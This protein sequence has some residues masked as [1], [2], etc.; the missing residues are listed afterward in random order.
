M[1][2]IGTILNQRFRLD[3]ELGR[4][5]MGAV[6]SA[7]D[8]ILQR[9]VAI[10]VLKERSG[11]EVGKKLR[12]EA[13]IAARL[14]HEN[15]VRIYDF[16]QA[17]GTYYLV[18][19]EVN[20]SSYSKRWRH[21]A[22]EDRL[23]ILSQVAEALD[24]AHH[25]GVVHRDIKPSNVLLTAANTPKLSDFGLSILVEQGDTS[26]LVRGTPL[27]MSPEQT[28][29]SQLD[30]RTDLYS[31]GVMLY[32]ST[33]G[34]P[35][36]S[37]VPMQI[38]VQHASHHPDP[39]RGR[40]PAISDDLEGLILSLL[41]KRPEDRPGSGSAVAEVLRQEMERVVQRP[42]AGATAA[43]SAGVSA[44]PT[45]VSPTEPQAPARPATA[46]ANGAGLTSAGS[47]PPATSMVS[48]S[49]RAGPFT[50]GAVTVPPAGPDGSLPASPASGS[51]SGV[52]TAPRPAVAIASVAGTGGVTA[53]IRSPL[54]RRMIE[55]VLAEPIMLSPE[56]RYLHGHYLAYLLS[57]S[58]RRGLFLR[59]PTDPR[60]AD[61]AR[62]LLGLTYAILAESTDEAIQDVAALLDQKI[63]VRPMLSPV[64][65]AKYLGGR[66]NPT[67]RKVFRQIRRA[68]A[69]ASAYAQQHMIDSKG[70]LNP[71][72]M[73]Q[74]LE[75]LHHV[76]PPRTEVDDVLVERW[77]RVAEVWRNEPDFRTAVLRYATK[78]AHRDPASTALWPE[79][80][81]PLIE[82][83]RWHRRI[84]SRTEAVWDYLCARVLRAPDAGVR[85]DRALDRAVPAPLVA[86][87]DE[88]LELLIENPRLDDEAA[89][90]FAAADE[91]DRL[92]ASITVSQHSLEE[93]AAEPA[94]FN[95]GRG[96]VPL[97]E[98]DPLRFLQGELHELW[99]EALTAMQ[100]GPAR[101]GAK[102]A[103]HRHVPVGPYRLAV[104]PSI[105]GRAAGQIA[106]QGMANK[107][108]ELT[109]PTVRTKGSAGKPLVA[110][111]V[112]SDNSLVIAHLDFVSAE[113]YVLWHAPRS[114]QLNFD[115]TAD[116]NHEL[117]S[118][119]MELPDHL[120]RALSRGFKPRNTV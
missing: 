96:I 117:Y 115:T 24:Y 8:E 73:P 28:K 23:R 98:P 76:A 49:A 37:G 120:D 2:D 43:G 93:I 6:Y 32:E 110:I 91:A 74:R 41:A 19:E 39:P 57:G 66:N 118:L 1:I 34:S 85:L 62:L 50:E 18:M 87:L 65:V 31:L 7:T 25:Q 90:P 29:G 71:G 83:A 38:M 26:G 3:K 104:I 94:D 102:P 52:G 68:I 33:T 54:A 46:A 47:L 56:E 10:K 103:G 53:L 48:Q 95:K 42:R 92:G 59:R 22:M 88:S 11:E 51:R 80:V 67:R 4:G 86:Q 36:F 100:Q 70:V 44:G 116:L 114:H 13:Q 72:L 99:K 69:Q 40:N 64:V 112:Y 78:E 45:S 12:L 9:N 17:D 109:T 35:P 101:P 15:V 5:G 16:A 89:D 61:R 75:D 21:L 63:E 14:L 81:Y 119:G 20:G 77:N 55:V 30:F 97:M 111:W 79:V 84:R 82:R 105:R 27:Y 107:Q 106:I 60:N 58:R 108:I 113:R